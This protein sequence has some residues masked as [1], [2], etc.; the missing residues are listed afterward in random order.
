MPSCSRPAAN[1]ARRKIPR[2]QVSSIIKG[3][4]QKNAL[5]KIKNRAFSNENVEDSG[6]PRTGK[7]KIP[8]CF[9]A[10]PPSAHGPGVMFFR[11]A[12]QPVK[13]LLAAADKDAALHN[14]LGQLLRIPV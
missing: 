4:N 6:I 3:K 14:T 5:T 12:V 2:L 9:D 8:Y 11:I 13:I 1:R 7:Y 10:S